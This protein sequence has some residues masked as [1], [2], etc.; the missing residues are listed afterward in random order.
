MPTYSS[1]L[2]VTTL[3]KDTS[4]CWFNDISSLYIPKGEEPVGSPNTKGLS[5]V[6]CDALIL[7]ATYRAAQ[8]DTVW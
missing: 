4:P 2:N 6:A 1:M 5:G 3:R 8:R 7:A